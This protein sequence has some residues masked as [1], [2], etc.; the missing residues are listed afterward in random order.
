MRAVRKF[1]SHGKGL[2]PKALAL[3]C[4]LALLL[5]SCTIPQVSAEERLFLDLSAEFLGEYVLS[6]QTFENFP[7]GGLSAIAYTP[8]QDRLYALSDD[9]QAPR[10]YVLKPTLRDNQIQDVTIESMT[11][12]KDAAGNP[13][14]KGQLDPE[15]IA[16]TPRNTVII[17]SETSPEGRNLPF[18]G[19]FNRTTGQLQTPFRI[20]E[21]YVTDAS[22]EV[23]QTKG[24]Q[25]NLGLEALTINAAPGSASYTEPF[26]LFVGTEGPL[27][28][29]MD[30]DPEIPFKNRVLHYLIGQ[31]QSTL[32]SEHWYPMDESPLGAVLNGL[33]ELL[34]LDP[35]GHFLALERA[36]GLQGF[37]IKLYQLAT[38]GASDVSA[39]ATLKGDISGLTPI[40]KQLMLSLNDLDI[41]L[42][43]LEGMTLGPRLSDGSQSLILVSD[44]NFDDLQQ[45]QFL[46]LRLNGLA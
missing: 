4:L 41:T 29:D 14:A 40:Q 46:L 13:Y 8:Q 26:R 43:N 25:T 2:K 5:T 20:P 35:G 36:F 7:V 28:Q 9:R 16:L 22:E 44:D 27:L 34:V 17:S 39:I 38:G 37:S 23:S 33:S 31:N 32:I 30:E 15:G 3:S 45:T 19:E 12:L 6:K 21:R 24:A 1:I 10:F 42:E 11:L 18:I